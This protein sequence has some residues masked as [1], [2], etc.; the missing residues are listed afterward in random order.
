MIPPLD[1]LPDDAG[2]RPCGLDVSDDLEEQLLPA[3]SD[4]D[5]IESPF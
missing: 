2:E 1:M 5:N 4:V 3:A